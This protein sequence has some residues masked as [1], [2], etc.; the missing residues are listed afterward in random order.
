MFPLNDLPSHIPIAGRQSEDIEYCTG[1]G[2]PRQMAQGI[3]EEKEQQS[4]TCGS[5]NL[6]IRNFFRTQAFRPQA[7]QG[8]E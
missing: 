1:S 3:V 2:T 6:L 4:A 8:K 5:D 7:A